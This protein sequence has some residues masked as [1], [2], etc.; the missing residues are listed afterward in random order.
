[1]PERVPALNTLVRLRTE[2]TPF[3]SAELEDLVLPEDAEA[4]YA[5]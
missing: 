4:G 1:L 3:R 5:R 2:F